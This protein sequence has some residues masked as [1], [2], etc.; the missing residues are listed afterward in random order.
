MPS[1]RIPWSLES[2][3]GRRHRTRLSAGD[4][5]RVRKREEILATLDEHGRLD[6]MPFM[7]EM[8]A[9]CG[10]T[11]RV[12]KRAHKTCDTICGYR[13]RT[14]ERTIHLV[15]SRCSGSAHGGC[16]AACSLFW[17]EAWLEPADPPGSAT[18]VSS[19]GS[20]PDRGGGCTMDQLMAATQDGC[21]PEKGPRYRCQTT[22]LLKATRPL[23]TYDPRQ[24][25]EDLRS[26]NVD[27]STI[28]RGLAY[29]ITDFLVR[30][31]GRVG[32]LMGVG[33]ALSRPLMAC[34][35]R[36]QRLLPNGVPYPRRRGTIP[37]G[38][39]T[40]DLGIGSLGPGSSV[41]VKSYREILATLDAKNKTRGMYFD[42]EHVPYCEKEFRIRS[43]VSR[44]VDEKTGY[45]MHF[46]APSIILESAHCQGR[47]SNNRMFC[48]RAIYPYWRPIWLKPV[49]GAN[50]G[51]ASGVRDRPGPGP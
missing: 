2:V 17:K 16:Q 35:D 26:G 41:R 42:A 8:L 44:I 23:S 48:P 10:Q 21:D 31:F 5:V 13:G 37:K 30:G 47:Y 43:L 32:R 11:L 3:P 49:D 4:W 40:P 36:V 25:F 34:Y 39:P 28:L 15:D 20:R 9:Q 51:S 46:K 6:G 33:D 50:E 14:L 45:L 22:D 18:D 38:E 24:Y 7:P 29:I 19:D 12:F 1:S 27:L